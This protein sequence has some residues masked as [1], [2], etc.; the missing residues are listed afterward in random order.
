MAYE[1]EILDVVRASAGGFDFWTY[2][3]RE[4]DVDTAGSEWEIP[5]NRMPPTPCVLT[6]Y[7]AEITDAGASGAT[8]LQP[9]V[10]IGAG[11]PTSGLRHIAST[12]VAAATI[13]T[14]TDK[15]IPA[16]ARTPS[17]LFRG[18]ST[19]DADDVPEITSRVTF[20]L[21]D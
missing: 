5:G 4:T 6:L 16:L 8:T 9:A 18:R 10:G 14:E 21:G 2:T 17:N 13:R 1:F 12:A 7:E 11:F 15:K 20:R 3:I 19:P